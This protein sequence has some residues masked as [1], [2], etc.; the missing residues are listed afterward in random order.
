VDLAADALG[1]RLAGLPVAAEQADAAG[2]ADGW[3][4]V[5]LLEQQPAAGADQHGGGELDEV[6]RAHDRY[7]TDLKRAMQV[8][9]TSSAGLPHV[10]EKISTSTGPVAAARPGHAP[11]RAPRCRRPSC[12]GR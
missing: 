9:S 5:A 4:V 11:S 12:R 8:S 2:V 1:K 10:S 7:T 3:D 6:G